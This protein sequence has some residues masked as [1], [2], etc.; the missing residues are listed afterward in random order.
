M[1]NAFRLWKEGT[2]GS[3]HVWGKVELDERGTVEMILF[4]HEKYRFLNK[5]GKLFGISHLDQQIRILGSLSEFD[6]LYAPYSMA[7]TKLLAVLKIFGLFRKPIVIAVHQ[8]FLFARSESRW[9][10]WISKVILMQFESVIFLSE[11][12][13]RDTVGRLNIPPK[14][15]KSRFSTAHWGPDRRFYKKFKIDIPL[16][17]CDYVISAGNTDRDYETIIEA[18]R[19]IDFKLKIFCSK[20][21]LPKIDNLPPNVEIHSE[22]IPYFQLSDHYLHARLILIPFLYPMKKEGC[23]G[24][25][26]IQDVLAFHKPV[27][28]TKNPYLNMDVEEEGFGVQ[29]EKQD[30][31]GWRNTLNGL[32]EDWDRL[33][34]MQSRTKVVLETK[35]NSD[36]YAEKLEEVLLSQK[37]K[38]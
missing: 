28:I 21:S 7:N 38:K 5:I 27:V 4:P 14:I 19:Y 31:E 22:V 8:P 16:E 35:M 3:H 10:R 37:N 36:I 13:M 29:V 17:S 33:K 24:M 23:Q 9:M 32:I 15:E 12:L 6:V 30:V 2:S 1:E 25:T 20:K 34:T 11:P 26:G 18:F